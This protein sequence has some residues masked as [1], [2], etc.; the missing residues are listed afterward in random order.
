MYGVRVSCMCVLLS[1]FTSTNT[2]YA[3]LYY[4]YLLVRAP[5]LVLTLPVAVL[6]RTVPCCAAEGRRGA[7]GGLPQPAPGLRRPERQVDAQPAHERLLS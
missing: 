1:T 5:R 3:H 4:W 7:A 6:A 2:V